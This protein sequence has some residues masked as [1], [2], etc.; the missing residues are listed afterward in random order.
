MWFSS[1]RSWLQAAGKS[2]PRGGFQPGPAR[3][4][5]R[6]CRPRLEV[7]EDRLVPAAPITVT[8]LNNEGPGSLRQA[9]DDSNANPSD[10]D[11]IVFQPGLSGRINLLTTAQSSGQLTVTGPVSI[12]GPG[13]GLLTISGN[14]QSRIFLFT[15]GSPSLTNYSLSGVT[16]TQGTA[17]GSQFGGAIEV[18]S[19]NLNLSDMVITDNTALQGGGIF[20]NTRGTLTL[21][22]STVRDNKSV[23]SG[24]GLF[25]AQDTATFIGNSTISGNQTLGDGTG[26]GVFFS[27]GSLTIENSTI[28]GNRATDA[29]GGLRIFGLRAAIR[30]STIAFNAADSDNTGDGGGGGISV[31]DGAGPVTLT[32]SIVAGNT[33]G[34]GS[35]SPDIFG[36]VAAF[37]S[38]VGN[39]AGTVFDGGGNNLLNVDP[40]LGPLAHNGGPTQTHALLAGSPAIN[41]GFTVGG[42]DFDQRGPGF[43]RVVGPAPDI[44]AFEVQQPGVVVEPPLPVVEIKVK[45]VK[46]RTRV[47]VLVDGALRRRFFPFGAF[48]GRVQVLRV[49]V[50][51]DGLFD[52]VA[53]ATVNGKR[54][55]RTFLT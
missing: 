20:V 5:Q 39:T 32:S 17:T 16:L 19:E 36:S 52:V 4:P 40:R 47:D 15:N 55:T 51:G 46:R 26:G 41:A 33:A 8:N 13:S 50:N 12:V 23:G 14:N 34:T 42:L 24:A 37:S 1:F 28:S 44:G 11:T 38:L 22:N 21:L 29:G 18:T 54:R 3:R 43:A 48:T 7:L 31:N 30:N 10:A 2:T 49:D 9:I 25:L 6:T 35:K 27:G 53:R 45:R